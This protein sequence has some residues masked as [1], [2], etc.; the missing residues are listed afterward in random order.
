MRESERV[1]VHAVA[2]SCACNSCKAVT[3]SQLSIFLAFS[4]KVAMIV[5]VRT[6]EERRRE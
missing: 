3:G 6:K 4:L 5:H 1:L 2:A